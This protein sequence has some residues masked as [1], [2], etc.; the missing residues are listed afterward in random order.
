MAKGIFNRYARRVL[1]SAICAFAFV[2]GASAAVIDGPAVFQGHTYYLL[3]ASS[4]SSAEAEA[5]AL[6]GHLVTISSQAENDFVFNRFTAS[7]TLD[8]NLWIGLS[9]AAQ[10]GSFT[11]VSGEPVTFTYWISTEPNNSF[12]FDG[13]YPGQDEDYVHILSYPLFSSLTN[14]AVHPAGQWNDFADL[15][16]FRGSLSFGVVEVDGVADVPLPGTV[17]LLGL[18]LAGIGAARRKQA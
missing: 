7:G 18:G 6:G 16:D 3:S 13:V 1:A 12:N 17:A 15:G 2:G 8:R 14:Y 10:E 11:W 5:V 9:D 4:W